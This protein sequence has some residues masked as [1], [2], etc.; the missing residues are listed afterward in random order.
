[1]TTR[2]PN[3]DNAT[4][5][6]TMKA[7]IHESYGA[8]SD[9]IRFA[10]TPRPVPGDDEVLVAVEAVGMAIGD[11]LITQGLPRIARP[12]YGITKPKEKIAGLEVAGKVVAAG[13]NVTRFE[14]G[15][16]VFGW[17][18]GALAEYVTV[19]GDNLM[20]KPANITMA[21]AA[22]VP[23]S[24]F[25]AL[26]ALRDAGRVQAGQEVLVVGASGAVG[27]FAVQIAKAFGATVTGVASTRNAE[28]VRS[29]GADHVV[30]Y[31]RR[32][33]TED[34]KQY[35]L[36][37]DMAGNRQ[38]RQI[39]GALTARGTLVIVGGSGGKWLMGFGRTIRAM[40][41]SPFVRHKLRSLISKP[42]QD[43]LAVLAGMLEAGAITPVVD[44]TYRI[45]STEHALNHIGE[46][47]TQ[48]KTVVTV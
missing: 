7:I 30:D 10:D 21:Q 14:S 9:A 44:R 48:G 38:L 1:M 8:P 18:S 34:T 35:D 6:T 23:I 45:E 5:I 16:A 39:R 42:N 11:W 27:T 26:Q 22:A 46:R 28:L 15:D 25:T 32:D 43:D 41:L 12:M 4:A 3:T 20:L 19:A 2:N 47:H 17:G 29:L 33:F 13:N 40:L 36:I 24:A 37:L 31:T